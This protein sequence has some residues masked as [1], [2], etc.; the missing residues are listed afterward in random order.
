MRK[1]YQIQAKFL[2]RPFAEGAWPITDLFIHLALLPTALQEKNSG[3]QEAHGSLKWHKLYVNPADE[4][5]AKKQP[6]RYDQ[7]FQVLTE[8]E[9]KP[10]QK[11]WVSGGAGSGKSTLLQRVAYDWSQ[12]T[13]NSSLA[14]MP[15]DIQA[16]VWIKLR[17]LKSYFDGE[18]IAH[19]LLSQ[20]KRGRILAHRLPHDDDGELQYLIALSVYLSSKHY[21]CWDRTQKAKQ[22]EGFLEQNASSILW[23]IDGYDEIANLDKSHPAQVIFHDF[24]LQQPWVVVTSRPYYRC[25]VEE[26]KPVN[27]FRQVELLGF[28]QTSLLAYVER[29]F[30]GKTDNPGYHYIKWLLMNDSIVA[31]LAHIPVNIEILCSV[32][33]SLPMPELGGKNTTQLYT[34]LLFHLLKRAKVKGLLSD[35]FIPEN[36]LFDKNL[37]LTSPKAKVLLQGLGKLAFEGLKTRQVQFSADALKQSLR[38]YLSLAYGANEKACFQDI[39]HTGFLGGLFWNQA[40]N[41]FQGQGAFLH[42]TLQEYLA[43]HY[44]VQAWLDSQ[45]RGELICDIARY[46][47]ARSF[48][49]CWPF[50]VG[51]LEQAGEITALEELASEF[52]LPP[53]P[54]T[55][56]YHTVLQIRCIEELWATNTPLPSQWQDFVEQVKTKIVTILL[57]NSE[58]VIF[59]FKTN[60]TWGKRLSKFLSKQF[61]AEDEAEKIIA[62]QCISKLGSNVVTE[63]LLNEIGELLLPQQTQR[64]RLSACQML[65]TLNVVAITPENILIKL[66]ALFQDQN[67]SIR[68]TACEAIRSFDSSSVTEETLVKLLP[69]LGDKR[70]DVR[71]AAS[72]TLAKFQSVI[73]KRTVQQ[74]L[75]GL[76][77]IRASVRQE[78]C[79]LIAPFLKS[80]KPESILVDKLFSLLKDEVAEVRSAASRVINMTGSF[81]ITENTITQLTALLRCGKA[82]I[83]ISTC[84]AIYNKAIYQAIGRNV[85]GVRTILAKLIELLQNEDPKIKESACKMLSH[86]GSFDISYLTLPIFPVLLKDPHPDVRIAVCQTIRRLG[87]RATTPLILKRLLNISMRD[88]VLMVRKAACMA[89]GALGHVAVTC[90]TL[91]CLSRL[92]QDINPRVRQFTCQTIKFLGS[93]AASREILTHLLVLLADEDWGV[94]DSASEAICNLLI[95]KEVEEWF[96][97]QLLIFSQS[98]ENRIRD[99]TCKIFAVLR[100]KDVDQIKVLKALL[101]FSKASKNSYVIKGLTQITK[102]MSFSTLLPYLGQILDA[103]LMQESKLNLKSEQEFVTILLRLTQSKENLSDISHFL[104]TYLDFQRKNRQAAFL[105]INNSLLLLQAIARLDYS[106]SVKIQST[107]LHSLMIFKKNKVSTFEISA[108]SREIYSINRLDAAGNI[109]PN[110]IFSISV[111]EAEN[112]LDTV[113]EFY[114]LLPLPMLLKDKPSFPQEKT[115]V[116][117]THFPMK[118]FDSSWVSE[119]PEMPE[120]LNIEQQQSWEEFVEIIKTTEKRIEET[121]GNIIALIESMNDKELYQFYLKLRDE[122]EKLNK[123]AAIC[124]RH[125][126]SMEFKK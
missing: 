109:V 63:E 26:H 30:A 58:A 1:I 97:E 22:W 100:Y 79:E 72:E 88:E 8:K 112:I 96:I 103:I 55:E 77:H 94:S 47:Y 4:L 11:I 21:D 98:K 27:P 71:L 33:S 113:N 48:S 42:L 31:G 45:K 84:L 68:K 61:H 106:L 90:H 15:S 114:L 16:V 104:Y 76:T 46:K 14:W 117:R 62:L 122:P 56:E 66:L 116:N 17:E 39:F 43:A 59:E 38:P 99:L 10:I 125:I 35:R 108:Q 5:I 110:L 52:D 89:I 34:L 81:A 118:F 119:M 37:F 75:A 101:N 20:A 64:V 91:A 93:E 49:R 12:S 70:K 107:L 57:S 36:N 80:A 123:I 74:L 19:A 82:E 69:L 2:I 13:E 29:H 105:Y 25:P 126:T 44:F 73:G 121:E 95:N 53:L 18:D 87:V 115:P 3:F 78:T 40:T 67:P 7:L 28:S 51:L 92:L 85:D 120:E 54:L 111:N 23:L 124:E 41:D 86:F 24:L 50:V 6:L 83:V 60:S 65:S 102:R 9:D 32:M